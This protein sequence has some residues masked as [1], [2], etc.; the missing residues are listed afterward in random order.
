MSI[1]DTVHNS[2]LKSATRR[3]STPGPL[4][5]ENVTFLSKA[6][7]KQVIECDEG[8]TFKK[9]FNLSWSNYL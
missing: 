2:A 8:P 3:E 6:P 5:I 4:T 1:P 9:I 7:K